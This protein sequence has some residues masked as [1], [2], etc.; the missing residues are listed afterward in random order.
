MNVFAG[1][2][3][4]CGG[5]KMGGA[6]LE[7]W[8]K[9]GLAADQTFIIEPDQKCA[10]IIRGFGTS[11]VYHDANALPKVELQTI[12]LAV[13]PQ[14]MD[15][16]SIQVK[17][18]VSA[19][20]MVVSVAAGKTIETFETAFGSKT[21]IVRVMPNTPAAIGE[22]MSVLCANRAT[23]Q[24]QRSAAETLLSAVGETAWI[25]DEELMHAVTA[26][27]GSGPAYVF[28]LIEALTNA[29][30]EA[31]LPQALANKLALQTIS[32]AGRLAR[33][34][35]LS[36]STLRENV[37]SPGGTTEAALKQLMAADGL[38]PLMGRAVKAATQR[39]KELA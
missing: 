6:L 3:L 30:I 22:G 31:G 19:S 34:S 20:T 5:G 29:G 24:S 13:K 16:V 14:I 35:D 38:G 39:S 23:S 9:R 33:E 11:N 32:G 17:D 10:E 21:A 37:T 12:V 36:A 28:Y 18:R 1:P 4:L 8:L 7:G 2:L 15:S 27:S 25:E 26:V